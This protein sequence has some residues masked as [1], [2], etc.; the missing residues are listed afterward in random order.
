MSMAET[1][2]H[3]GQ[4][5]DRLA[6]EA[7]QARA[8]SRDL[9]GRQQGV[10]DQIARVERQRDQAVVASSAPAHDADDP[11]WRTRAVAAL[12]AVQEHL[13]AVPRELA[14]AREAA[15]GCR[16]A[17]TRAAA[18][19]QEAEQAASAERRPM[20]L[21]AAEQAERDAEDAVGR[22]DKALAPLS[23]AT[24]SAWA[25][26]LDAF[27]P[28]AGGA[29]DILADEL[30]AAMVAFES[31]CRDNDPDA[32]SSTSAAV[33][34]LVDAVQH[35]LAEA[36]ATFTERDPLAAAR[37]F[38]RAAADSLAANPADL[39]AA[40][41]HQANVTSALSRAWDR[42]I[43][44][45]AELR[46][47]MQPSFQSLYVPALPAPRDSVTGTVLTTALPGREW[48]PTHTRAGDET[49]SPFRETDPAG[50]EEPLRLYFESLGKAQERAK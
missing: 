47:S 32:V 39:H 10:A 48:R 20:L 15:L 12:L 16:K 29:R 41:A 26:D 14:M 34:E 40:L 33:R 35:E 38:A 24:V 36:Q 18:A 4:T 44:R 23:P 50:Y 22:L 46:L 25:D 28:E 8:A 11:S 2:D 1:V 6:Q 5:Q 45:A 37:L 43:H 21:R 30:P 31:A 3:L 19:A 17:I 49:A 42:S 13:A 27:T 9:I 7:R